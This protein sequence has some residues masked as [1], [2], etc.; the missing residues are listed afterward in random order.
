LEAP[1]G[2]HGPPPPHCVALKAYSDWRRSG[3]GPLVPQVQAR[4]QHDT[5]LKTN[6]P[7]TPKTFQTLCETVS[8]RLANFRISRA[9]P[10]LFPPR[11]SIV[12]LLL[13]RGGVE[14]YREGAGQPG[15]GPLPH[16]GR[17]LQPTAKEK[18]V[19]YMFSE[20]FPPNRKT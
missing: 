8:Q 1:P 14:V 18:F 12:Y 5:P 7:F 13:G 20:N 2:G 11:C 9:P 17:H 10:P 19:I 3:G 16:P 4:Q 15:R 6:L